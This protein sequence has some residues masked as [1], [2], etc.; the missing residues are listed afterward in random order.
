M[1]V[2]DVVRKLVN[3]DCVFYAEPLTKSWFVILPTCIK[4]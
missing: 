1:N 4:K 3:E 2:L